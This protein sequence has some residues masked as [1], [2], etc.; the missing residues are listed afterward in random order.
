[1]KTKIKQYLVV[2]ISVMIIASCK[3]DEPLAPEVIPP[4][5]VIS[6][7]RSF[8][9][10]ADHTTANITYAGNS[11]TAKAALADDKSLVIDI[12]T[13]FPAGSDN[14]AFV[15]PQSKI[16]AGYI[17]D[18][19][20]EATSSEASIYYQYQL[21]S[22]SS[23]KLLP[24]SALGTIKIANYDSKF[25]TLSGQFTFVINAQSDPI[26]S[27]INNFRQTTIAVIGNFENVAIK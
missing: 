22:T 15:I 27:D 14:V 3:K 6:M 10:V 11:I 19:I 5:P 24:G 23:N 4:L 20:S 21:T 7:S 9:Y 13:P 26:S 1:M 25:K 8:I 2:L 16:K 12:Q 17:G 18:Y